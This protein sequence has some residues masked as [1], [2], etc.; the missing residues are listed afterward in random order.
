MKQMINWL[1]LEGLWE[2]EAVLD[3]TERV[4]I[5]CDWRM[6]SKVNHTKA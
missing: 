1:T 5:L 4:G 2:L 3:S 6:K